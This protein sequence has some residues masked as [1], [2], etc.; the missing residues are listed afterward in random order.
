MT[1]SV[2]VDTLNWTFAVTNSTPHRRVI[3]YKTCIGDKES[4]CKQYN[5]WKQGNS[6]NST[7]ILDKNTEEK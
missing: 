4:Y 7:Y 1:L 2:K 5:C 6:C 3:V